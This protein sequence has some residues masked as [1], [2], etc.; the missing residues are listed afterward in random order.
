MDKNKSTLARLISAAALI[1]P[2]LLAGCQGPVQIGA[3]SDSAEEATPTP[4]P[5]SPAL[6]KATFTVQRGEV[7]NE[8][9]FSG[10][11]VPESQADLFFKSSGR[12]RTLYVKEGETIQAGQLIADLEGIDDLMRRKDVIK[13]G[14]RRSEIYLEMAKIGLKMFK[15]NTPV[16]LSNY[17]D[18][19]QIKEY[20]VELAQLSV[21][22]ARLSLADLDQALA[23]AQI[24]APIAGELITLD[25]RA[26]AGVDAYQ[27]VGEVADTS[28]L[29]IAADLLLE[30]RS[31]LAP[32]MEALITVGSDATN[33]RSAVV[34]RLP[35]D[36]SS[37][38]AGQDADSATRIAFSSPEAAAGLE[39]NQ[40]V[41][42]RVVI[43]RKADVLW[44]PPAAVRK[45]EGRRFVIV[46]DGNLQRRVDITIGIESESRIEIIE[47]LDEGQIIQGN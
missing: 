5:T 6:V 40:L 46:L 31:K 42:V 47:G 45:F 18:N 29:E 30:T 44:L 12:I 38:T 20:E 35:S 13:I 39:L 24:F 32:G 27:V 2:M 16:W 33:T 36:R 11:V 9:T 43:E 41:N 4:L 25:V 15:D 14:V 3:S 19:L 28:K 1:I 10:R 21:D 7:V 22:E 37:V 26:G 8:V 17:K 23:N 34:R